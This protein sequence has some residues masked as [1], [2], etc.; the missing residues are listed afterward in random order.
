MARL[1][2]CEQVDNSSTTQDA[3]L[4]ISDTDLNREH[5]IVLST[6]CVCE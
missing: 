2:A 4:M 1:R 5:A 6:L 3:T